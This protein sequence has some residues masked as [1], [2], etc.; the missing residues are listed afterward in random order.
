LTIAT[1]IKGLNYLLFAVALQTRKQEKASVT[2]VRRL[3][4]S[5]TA[6]GRERKLSAPGRGAPAQTAT[7]AQQARKAREKRRN[8]PVGRRK[9]RTRKRKP[10]N[11]KR[12]RSERRRKK[13]LSG[14]KRSRGNAKRRRLLRK[15]KAKRK[16]RRKP[17]QAVVRRHPAQASH[18][19]VARQ[20]EKN[21]AAAPP[22]L[23]ACPPGPCSSPSSL[24]RTGRI[25]CV[26]RGR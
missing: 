19:I 3:R 6:G 23:T 5:L 24:W 11:T 7:T 17:G 26:V 9:K 15:R 12:S 10:K 14:R 20:A 18:R 16:R 25:T 1:E 4:R 22:T 21:Q 2:A 8:L 13:G